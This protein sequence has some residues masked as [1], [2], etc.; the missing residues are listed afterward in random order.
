M[1]FVQQLL[2][3]RW[4]DEHP[5]HSE[6]QWVL[7]SPKS[8]RFL[9]ER[10]LAG[11][12]ALFGWRKGDGKVHQFRS[13]FNDTLIDLDRISVGKIIGDVFHFMFH[14]NHCGMFNPKR[15]V[16]A[17]LAKLDLLYALRCC[18]IKTAE[19]DGFSDD[20]LFPFDCWEELQST[21]IDIENSVQHVM[22]CIV[23]LNVEQD[24]KAKAKIASFINS[25]EHLDRVKTFILAGFA[26]SQ[27]GLEGYVFSRFLWFSRAI[28]K[29]WESLLTAQSLVVDDQVRHFPLHRIGLTTINYLRRFVGLQPLFQRTPYWNHSQ[30]QN[31]LRDIVRYTYVC[32]HV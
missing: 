3:G 13:E 17:P 29:D 19:F 2:L 14:W 5:V 32:E 8:D 25:Y 18:L 22:R 12:Y 1:N 16:V 10:T 20:R 28:D 30:L 15:S 31:A 26:R 4:T 27:K 7:D 11:V 23:W 21:I 24:L 6:Y 9:P